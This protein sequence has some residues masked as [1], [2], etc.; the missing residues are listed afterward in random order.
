[1]KKTPVLLPKCCWKISPA[2]SPRR[3][4]C[5]RCLMQLDARARTKSIL[6]SV[7]RKRRWAT[8]TIAA[9]AIWPRRLPKTSAASML[10]VATSKRFAPGR[11]TRWCTAR[12]LIQSG[13]A[14]KVAVVAGGSLAKLG[15][16]FE[17][18]LKKN[19]PVLED[20]LG[21]FAV[22]LSPAKP[23]RALRAARF[24]GVSSGRRRRIAPGNGGISRRETARQT[25]DE[26]DRCRSLR[27]GAA[28]SRNH[29]AVGQRRRAAD[30]LS[31]PGGIGGD[32][33]PDSEEPNGG[34]CPHPRHARLCADARPYS[35]GDCLFGARDGRACEAAR[36]AMRC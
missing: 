15:M 14:K 28:Q 34:F 25:G 7:A 3:I 2:K 22:I 33:R 10:P 36:F 27:R 32:A 30:E 16:K 6:S 31:D 35:L 19:M 11:C 9:A 20:V 13:V 8:G 5:A 29:R 24:R 23:G 17:S 21:S 12:V 1:M 4:R 18:H 26:T